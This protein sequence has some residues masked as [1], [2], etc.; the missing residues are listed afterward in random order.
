MVFLEQL[1]QGYLHKQTVR[2][3]QV[4]S[5]VINLLNFTRLI[6]DIDFGAG[7]KTL[8]RPLINQAPELIPSLYKPVSSTNFLNFHSWS[9]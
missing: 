5:A 7:D 4:L 8:I 3:P 2:A 1:T 9:V 6:N